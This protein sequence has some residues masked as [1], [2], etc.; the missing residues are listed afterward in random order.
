MVSYPV[1]IQHL[2][3]L[4]GGGYRKSSELVLKICRR[5]AEVVAYSIEIVD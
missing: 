2:N 3:P 4:H 5:A 1:F